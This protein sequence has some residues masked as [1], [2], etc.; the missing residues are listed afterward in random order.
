MKA[1]KWNRLLYHCRGT[2]KEI[3]GSA[4]IDALS[5]QHQEVRNRLMALLKTCW[6]DSPKSQQAPVK[7]HGDIPEQRY[8]WVVTMNFFI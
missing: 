3:G 6:C 8:A 7:S 1:A 5:N 2:S 4:K